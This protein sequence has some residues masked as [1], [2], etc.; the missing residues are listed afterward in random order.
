[1]V[2]IKKATQAD[3]AAIRNLVRSAR[4][5]PTGLDWRR[6]LVAVDEANTLIGCGQIKPHDKHICE[7]ASIAVQPVYRRQGIARALIETL[8]EDSL[9][10]G[11]EVYLTCRAELEPFYHKFGFERAKG[12]IPAYFS[13]I[14]GLSRILLFF[15]LNKQAILVMHYSKGGST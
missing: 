12:K 9:L 10:P 6:F 5:N 2:N 1:M 7:L 3:Q 14:R 4:I 11:C 15:H 8:L 13:M